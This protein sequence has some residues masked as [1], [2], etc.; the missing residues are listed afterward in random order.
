VRKV[1]EA[2]LDDLSFDQI[3]HMGTVGVD[4]EDFKRVRAA[5]TLDSVG[6]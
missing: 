6:A 4:P 3:V 5:A 2:G 1:R